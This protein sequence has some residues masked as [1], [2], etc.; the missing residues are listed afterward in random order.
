MDLNI[1][2]LNL[3]QLD[4]GN[5][6]AQ[7]HSPVGYSRWMPQQSRELY[8]CCREGFLVFGYRVFPHTV[9]ML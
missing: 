5:E 8:C 7:F 6:E 9:E 4:S 3:S 2:D 1:P